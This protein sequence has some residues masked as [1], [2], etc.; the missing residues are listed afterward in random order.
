MMPPIIE[1]KQRALSSCRLQD[2]GIAAR[3]QPFV[4]QQ[5]SPIGNDHGRLRAARI[6]GCMTSF[7]RIISTTPASAW[8]EATHER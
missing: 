1:R 8:S 7:C 3:L 5:C 4:G 6:A 2:R